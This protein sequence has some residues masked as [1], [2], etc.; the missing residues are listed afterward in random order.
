MNSTAAAGAGTQSKYIA[1]HYKLLYLD[2]GKIYRLIGELRIKIKNLYKLVKKKIKTIRL[3]NLSKKIYYLIK[4]QFLL[5][6]L[7]KIKI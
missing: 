7:L 3:R 2:T 1:K 5:Q 6:L 4:L